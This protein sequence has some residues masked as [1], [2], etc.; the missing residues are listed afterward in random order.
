M[1][2]RHAASPAATTTRGQGGSVGQGCRWRQYA[3]TVH[4]KQVDA[5]FLTDVLRASGVLGERSGVVASVEAEPVGTGQMGDS[6]RFHLAYEGD[7][8]DAPATVV[9]K[10][11]AE[12]ERSRATG[13]VMRSYEIEVRF[14]QELAHDLPICTPSMLHADVDPTT[15]DFVLIL[16]DLAPA[17]QGD[18]LAGCTPDEAALA[19]EQLAELH[20]PLWG[21]PRLESYDW[22]HR[23]GEEAYQTGENLLPVLFGGF[24]DRYASRVDDDHLAMGERLVPL[25]GRYLREQ[26]RPWTVQHGDYRVDNMLFASPQGGAPLTVVDWQTVTHGPGLVDASYLLGSS[27]TV[28]DRRACETDLLRDYRS[29]LGARGVQGLSWDECWEQYRRYAYSGYIMA[30]GASMMVEQT[31]RGDEMF[32]TM[33]RRHGTHVLDLESESLLRG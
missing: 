29:A 20:A 17:E 11:A 13:L 27:L 15:G 33:A 23:S 1:G 19:L 21:N 25:I 14:Y 5:A 18:Q 24:G 32:M 28:D 4:P 2:T 12:D 16:S 6:V 8:D 9:G 3:A 30:V 7:A 31:E 22:L 10:F 26:A